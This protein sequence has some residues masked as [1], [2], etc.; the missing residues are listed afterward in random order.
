MGGININKAVLLN[1]GFHR[2][3][4]MEGSLLLLDRNFTAIYFEIGKMSVLTTKFAENV[5]S[6]I[7]KIKMSLLSSKCHFCPVNVTSVH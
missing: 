2:V 5:S 4:V 6:V 7:K 1:Q 3:G